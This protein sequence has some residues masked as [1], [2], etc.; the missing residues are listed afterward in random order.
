MLV[1]HR[2]HMLVGIRSCSNVYAALYAI[3]TRGTYARRTCAERI[4]VG[5]AAS[6]INT[7]TSA[8]R[9]F[10]SEAFEVFMSAVS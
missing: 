4:S 5:A 6:S 8:S 10:R 2:A 3:R 9:S 7:P 1:G